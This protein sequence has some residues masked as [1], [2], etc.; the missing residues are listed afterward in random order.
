[1]PSLMR[2]LAPVALFS[3]A[4]AAHP[5]FSRATIDKVRANAVSAATLSWEIGTMM[6]AVTELDAPGLAVFEAPTVPVSPKA[7][8]P[9]AVMDA[10]DKS[11]AQQPKGAKYYFNTGAVGDSASIGVTALIAGI[12]TGNATYLSGAKEQLDYLLYDAP[13]K[14]VVISHR[15][16]AFQAWADFVSMAPPFIAYAGVTAPTASKSLLVN[17]YEQCQGYRSILQDPAGSK[18]W[19]HIIG[20]SFN[21]T[22]LWLTGNAWAA[23]GMLRVQQTIAKSDFADDLKSESADLL[24]WTTEILNATWARQHNTGAMANYLDRS[25]QFE[26][27]AGTALLAAAQYRI[28]S[29]TGSSLNID[30]AERA[31]QR[32]MDLIDSSGWLH[33]PVD[34]LAFDKQTSGDEHSP[35]A[36]SFVLMLDAASRA[37]YTSLS[38][39][40]TINLASPGT[41]ASS[42]PS[43]SP[44][45]TSKDGS[46]WAD[47]IAGVVQDLSNSSGE[48]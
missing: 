17:A 13:H 19:R 46:S 2:S 47:V 26:D 9:R 10:L 20:G 4:V 39:K 44:S 38:T 36:Q 28:A 37:Y 8:P 40:P 11:L 33:G 5:E 25:D 34:P 48:A 15:I 21:D 14:G 23:Y 42:S 24:D 30:A 16:E 3:L 12:S 31:L 35:E 7:N 22:G 43:S 45:S 27:S 41:A 1:M 29:I 32:V 18:L 6:E